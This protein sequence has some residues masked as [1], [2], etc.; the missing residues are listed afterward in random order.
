MTG[1]PL[2][3]LP[4]AGATRS[5]PAD[6]LPSLT[7]K[8]QVNEFLSA[9][10]AAKTA[11]DAL[12]HQNAAP[13]PSGVMGHPRIASEA[14]AL[15]SPALPSAGEVLEAVNLLTR[16]A[17]RSERVLLRDEDLL[18]LL[19]RAASPADIVNLA[20]LGE[21]A[22][23]A[24][25]P[26]EVDPATADAAEQL[27]ASLPRESADVIAA[28]DIARGLRW[29]TLLLVAWLALW[30]HTGDDGARK[31]AE[32]LLEFIGLAATARELTTA[33]ASRLGGRPE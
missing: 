24:K 23:A 32:V 14:V 9:M 20:A 1:D 19:T 17:I 2:D 21:A 16:P 5:D 11:A 33:A 3:W 15:L 22:L 12:A 7:L 25:E 28:A 30:L 26:F 10:R 13:R 8:S 6:A 27:H 18:A 31:A 4:P 29:A